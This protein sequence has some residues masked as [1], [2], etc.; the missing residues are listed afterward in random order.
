[1]NWTA[2]LIIYDDLLKHASA[3]ANLL[4]FT[5]VSFIHIRFWTAKSSEI[6]GGNLTALHVEKAEMFQLSNISYY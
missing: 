1:M 2:N 3:S 5:V 4:L 6:P